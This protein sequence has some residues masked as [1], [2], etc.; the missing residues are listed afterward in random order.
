MHI[1][2]SFICFHTIQVGNDRTA[3]STPVFLASYRTLVCISSWLIQIL[4]AHWG[5]CYSHNGSFF[6]AW[7]PKI[8]MHYKVGGVYSFILYMFTW[9]GGICNCWHMPRVNLLYEPVKLLHPIDVTCHW[10]NWSIV[11]VYS[12]LSNRP[13]CGDTILVPYLF[14]LTTQSVGSM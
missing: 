3:C 1:M 5:R 11:W 13:S 12:R 4:Y 9:I 14:S 7:F 6:Y 10:M 8:N 2:S